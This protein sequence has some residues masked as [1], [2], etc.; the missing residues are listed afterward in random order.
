M[1][2]VA[3]WHGEGVNMTEVAVC[4]G[5][6]MMQG[7]KGGR[8]LTNTPLPQIQGQGGG[9]IPLSLGHQKVVDLG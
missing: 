6:G 3:V 7:R 4:D 2:E 8:Q 9:I 5:V 1:T